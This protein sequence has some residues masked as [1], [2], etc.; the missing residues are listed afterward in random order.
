MLRR[1]RLVEENVPVAL[2][3]V[4][5]EGHRRPVAEFTRAHTRR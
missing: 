1:V 4:D 2:E 3:R 5:I